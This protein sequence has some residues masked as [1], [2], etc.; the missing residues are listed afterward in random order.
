MTS[1]VSTRDRLSNS[2]EARGSERR[3]LPAVRLLTGAIL[4]AAAGFGLAGPLLAAVLMH[5]AGAAEQAAST[6][7]LA[8]AGGAVTICLLGSAALAG[9]GWRR[10]TGELTRPRAP[11]GA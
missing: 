11:R 8:L 3:P 9:A 7:P 1:I 2:T 10:R 5:R 6:V 4:L